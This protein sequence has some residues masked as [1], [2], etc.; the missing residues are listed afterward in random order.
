MEKSLNSSSTHINVESSTT[1]N[2]HYVH[3]PESFTNHTQQEQL[4]ARATAARLQAE[5]MKRR[6]ALAAQMNRQNLANLRKSRTITHQQPQAT[7][8]NQQQPHQ[9]PQ[10]QPDPSSIL[11][12]QAAKNRATDAA[13]QS[14]ALQSVAT[15][16]IQQQQSQKTSNKKSFFKKAS[17]K[18]NR[19]RFA[20]AFAASAACVIALGLIVKLNMPDLSV[21]VAAL[22][23]GIEATYPSYIP[24]GYQL[25]GVSTGKN[26]SITMDFSGENGASF[27]LTEEK[28]SWDSNALLNNYVKETWDTDYAVIREQGITIYLSNSDA[29][30]VNGGILYH[31]SS[32]SADTLTKKEIKNLVTSL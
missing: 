8:I 13:L 29:T 16:D 4:S 26:D 5:A 1:L 18:Q 27:R 19:G 6:Q 14:A 25:A 3:R 21:R 31:L 9:H 17:Q 23:T 10:Q 7:P 22:Q 30:W 24:N 2:R 11:L 15:S 32:P 28:S 20:L 12:A